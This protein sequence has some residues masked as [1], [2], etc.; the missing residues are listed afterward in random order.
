MME[1]G[2]R[3]AAEGLREKRRFIDDNGKRLNYRGVLITWPH[4]LGC[5]VILRQCASRR[6]TEALH[7]A[8][9]YHL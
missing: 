7:Q 2:A 9:I 4:F 8:F 3:K 6:P 1:C 5:L